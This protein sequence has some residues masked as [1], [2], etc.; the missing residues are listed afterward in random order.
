MGRG[1]TLLPSQLP[2]P[3]KKIKEGGRANNHRQQL[4]NRSNFY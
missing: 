3:A 1:I 2:L 4:D